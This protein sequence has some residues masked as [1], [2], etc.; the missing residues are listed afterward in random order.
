MKNDTSSLKSKG[1]DNLWGS[2]IP[3][4][5][6]IY[7]FFLYYWTPVLTQIIKVNDN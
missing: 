4:K 7:M 6:K 1:L 2:A 3:I 5:K